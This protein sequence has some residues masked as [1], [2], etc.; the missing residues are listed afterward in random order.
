MANEPRSNSLAGQMLVRLRGGGKIYGI[1][2]LL[3]I[4]FVYTA[5]SSDRFLMGG[6]VENLVHRTALFG[7][8]SV[9][10]AFVIITGGI[11]LSIGSLVCLVGVLLPFLLT[12]HDWSVPM[13]VATLL[14]L[15][16]GIG[17]FHG[18]LITKLR[19]QP[20]VVTLCGL[21]LYRGL[22]RGITNDQSQGRATERMNPGGVGCVGGMKGF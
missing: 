8:L 15:S 12:K 19:L 20:F 1:R 16:L 13:A 3:V 18:V 5:I 7:I 22:A 21:L 14:G 17:L 6:N 10:A 4:I 2:G 11:D 9:G